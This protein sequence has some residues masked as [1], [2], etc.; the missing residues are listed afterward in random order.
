ME[1]NEVRGQE[2]PQS[3]DRD[4]ATE[5]PES[6][7]RLRSDLLAYIPL[8]KLQ[9]FLAE[10]LHSDSEAPLELCYC[11]M[12][13]HVCEWRLANLT[14]VPCKEHDPQAVLAVLSDASHEKSGNRL[15]DRLDVGIGMFTLGQNMRF[16]YAND[17]LLL[18]IGCDRARFEEECRKDGFHFVHPDDVPF[19][20]DEL[21]IAVRE[22]HPVTL[23]HRCISLADGS[24]RRF[25]VKAVHVDTLPGGVP[26][27]LSLV[28]DSTLREPPKRLEKP[29]AELSPTRPSVLVVDDSSVN[30]EILARILRD[31]YSVMTAKDGMTA[32]NVLREH[33]KHIAA[34]LLDIE[35]P[36]MNGHEFLEAKGRIAELD[37][38]PVIVVTGNNDSDNELRALRSGAWDFVTKPY[39][40]EII[41]FRLKNAILRSQ[42]S[43]FDELK[44]LAEYDTLTGIF[45]KAKFFSATEEML[46]ANPQTDFVFIRF[47]V[48]RFNLVNSYYGTDEGDSLLKYIAQM[49]SAFT[50]RIPLSTYGRIE[51]DVFCVC[52]PFLGM[53]AVTNVVREGRERLRG[54]PLNFDIVPTCGIYL[55]EDHAMPA[56]RMYDKANLAAKNCKGDYMTIF[57]VYDEEMGRSVEKEQE[58]TNEMSQAMEQGQFVPFFQ[59]KFNL[60]TRRI[61]GAEALVRWI[62]PVKKLV[63]P[64]EFIPV[65]ERNGFISQLDHSIWEQTCRLLRG[66]ADSGKPL[67]PVSVNVSR[68]DLYNPHLVESICSLTRSYGIP[69]DLLNLEI[70]ESAYM[71][72]PEMM[73]KITMQLQEQGFAI[74]MDD[75]GSGYSSLNVLK[76]IPVDVLK[77]DMRFLAEASVPER[78]RNIISSVVRMAQTLGIPTVAEGVEKAEQAE[79]LRNIGCDYG[80]G[81]YFAKPMPAN[82]YE[83]MFSQ[84]E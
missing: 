67:Y 44:Y 79:F 17:A 29:L 70:T 30:R 63:S 56:N 78:G 58:I 60:W 11:A 19:V 12:N 68:V 22:D 82:D 23:A 16:L 15:L 65:F 40:P 14:R 5:P 26:L 1:A 34:V 37:N 32:L 59:P 8:K 18:L 52:F 66:W 10:A 41:R 83:R 47:D 73:K 25:S 50:S 31:D 36:V 21:A 33:A 35:M 6:G 48:N 7:A 77:I 84:G 76:D 49:L 46:A 81:Y 28:T 54:Y 61:A 42:L 20:R 45:N 62:H 2:S 72:N 80:Q 64:A 51:A 71:D 24:I 43:A 57:R 3:I 27:F 39:R 9:N 74:L 13:E 38:I 69:S 75:F 53:D 4:D 55:V